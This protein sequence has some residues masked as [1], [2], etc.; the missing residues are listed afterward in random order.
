MVQSAQRNPQGVLQPRV[1]GIIAHAAERTRRRHALRCTW[2]L[3]L[4]H[5]RAVIR[6]N[7]CGVAPQ[8]QTTI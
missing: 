3:G 5:N 8:V 2:R 7:L 4:A 6:Q 1:A